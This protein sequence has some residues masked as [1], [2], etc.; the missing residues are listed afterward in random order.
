MS[1][2]RR[3]QT[4]E[5]GKFRADGLFNRQLLLNNSPLPLPHLQNVTNSSRIIVEQFSEHS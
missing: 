5:T 2:F 3:S 1:V 4:L